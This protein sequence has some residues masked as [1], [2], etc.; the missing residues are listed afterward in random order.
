MDRSD[1]QPAP[2][3]PVVSLEQVR[4]DREK[5]KRRKASSEMSRIEEL[6]RMTDLLNLELFDLKR[7]HKQLVQEFNRLLKLLQDKFR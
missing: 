6:E 5:S 7:D 4:R 2:P 1:D 3:S